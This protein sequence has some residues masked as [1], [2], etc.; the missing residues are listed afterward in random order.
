MINSFFGR[1]AVTVCFVMTLFAGHAMAVTVSDLYEAEVPVEGQEAAQRSDAISRAFTEVLMKVTGHRGITN[2]QELTAEIANASRYAQQYRYRLLDADPV[3][4]PTGQPE[5]ENVEPQRLL[6]VSFDSGAVNSM[7][8]GLGLP[9]W[10]DNRPSG[11][12]WIGL[13]QGGKR[14]L[15]NPDLNPSDIVS[16]M[17]SHAGSR[18]LP[19]I[20]PLMD[21]EDQT[22]MQTADLWGDF[23]LNI[24]NASQRYQPDLILTGT[25][26][27][28]ANRHWRASWRL[29]HGQQVS[30]W[31]DQ[32]ADEAS[33]AESAIERM[34]DLLAERFAPLGADF[35]MNKV[36][37]RIDGITNFQDYASLGRFLESQSTIEKAALVSVEPDAMIYDLHTRGGTQVL[38]QGLD[39]GGILTRGNSAGSS[40]NEQGIDLYYRLR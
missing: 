27:R 2:R 18:G 10:G 30:S 34:A 28:I 31:E 21:L 8:R 19:V 37:I 12:V 11:L 3:A 39:L 7:L 33:L 32:S 40:D 20:F 23:E 6:Q 22:N 14:Q 36:R 25:L 5:G 26:T 13:E 24:R 4:N 9:V 15:L 1:L 17:K 16:S 38:Q 29:Y 35:S